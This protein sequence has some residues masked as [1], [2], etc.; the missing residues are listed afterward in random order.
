MGS[1]QGR[2][3]SGGGGSR[4]NRRP[5]PSNSAG[6]EAKPPHL[7]KRHYFTLVPI[8][9]LPFQFF[10]PSNGPNPDLSFNFGSC[11]SQSWLIQSLARSKKEED[12]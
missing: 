10:R 7:D 9:P 5:P 11:Q 4:G 6:T 12:R 1:H 3:K 8:Y 2:R